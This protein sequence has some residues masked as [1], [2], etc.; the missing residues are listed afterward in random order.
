MGGEAFGPYFCVGAVEE[1]VRG[2]GRVQWGALTHLPTTAYA[3]HLPAQHDAHR[4][5]L[6]GTAAERSVHEDPSR[7]KQFS[8]SLT[9]AHTI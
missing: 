1:F 5:S 6:R 8:C 4:R 9:P 7:P 3:P 2:A